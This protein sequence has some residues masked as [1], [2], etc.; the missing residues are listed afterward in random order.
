MRGPEGHNPSEELERLRAPIIS[1]SKNNLREV[2]LR[3]EDLRNKTVLDLGA[4]FGPHELRQR[5][6][7]IDAIIVSLSKHEAGFEKIEHRTAVVADAFA[8]NLPFKNETFDIIMDNGG[9]SINYGVG[10]PRGQ[11]LV[12]ECLRVTKPGG[13]IRLERPFF[14]KGGVTKRTYDFAKTG[15]APVSREQIEQYYEQDIKSGSNP[16]LYERDSDGLLTSARLGKGIWRDIYAKLPKEVQRT[17]YNEEIG[18]MMEPFLAQSKYK[19]LE[20]DPSSEIYSPFLVI[21]KS[22]KKE[23]S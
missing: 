3:Y 8:P 15:K 1:H 22:A 16:Q 4:G 11:S 7:N 21:E 20:R 10:D 23:Q 5:L 9:P 17:I 12:A 13:E 14:W 19:I 18:E 2:G 6:E